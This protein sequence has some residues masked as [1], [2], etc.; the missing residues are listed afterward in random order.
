LTQETG[1]WWALVVGKVGH[2]LIE[3]DMLGCFDRFTVDVVVK[4]V[5]HCTGVA[6]ED[7]SA[8]IIG[9]L[10]RASTIRAVAG[11]GEDAATEGTEETKIRF[12]VEFNFIRTLVTVAVN[13]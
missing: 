3:A 1:V 13:G 2:D 6:K 7:T 12:G 4:D 11:D 9:K 8:D 10:G 5:L